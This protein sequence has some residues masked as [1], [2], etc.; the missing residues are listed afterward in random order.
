MSLLSKKEGFCEVNYDPSQPDI[1][2]PV[3][4]VLSQI[5]GESQAW[6]WDTINTPVDNTTGLP[7]AF[8]TTL[9][10]AST[11]GLGVAGDRNVVL[12]T[13]GANLDGLNIQHTGEQ[14]TGATGR[15]YFTG[16]FTVAEITESSILM[17]LAITD[18]TVIT[19]P[20]DGLF[21]RKADDATTLNLVAV[22]NSVETAV[23]MIA[24]IV[25]ATE[26][27]IGFVYDAS[28]ASA[29]G[30]VN[31]VSTGA[32]ITTNLPNDEMMTFSLAFHTGAAAA[33]VLYARDMAV[34]WI[35]GA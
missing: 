14:W 24:P 13:S 26:Y 16:K 8:T 5:R 30:Y 2:W 35:A 7:T 18:T 31:G 32:A 1:V 6:A 23:A 34:C 27:Q 11:F 3:C 17:G 15:L 28:D 19:A 29:Q 25:T 9:I 12:T 10:N 4:T 33:K 20:T 21:F 22:K